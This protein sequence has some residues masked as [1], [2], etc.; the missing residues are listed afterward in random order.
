MYG[1]DWKECSMHVKSK[2]AAQCKNF[3]H[4]FK[5]KVNFDDALD[6]HSQNQQKAFGSSR[7]TRSTV[8]E[9]EEGNS[10]SE[11]VPSVPDTMEPIV[12]PVPM[13]PDVCVL[14]II[15]QL[16]LTIQQRMNFCV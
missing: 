10:D 8:K 7:V 9:S 11:Y 4:N 6:K 14:Q 3:Y 15:L 13:T 1:R 5:R 12:P 16:K 2:T